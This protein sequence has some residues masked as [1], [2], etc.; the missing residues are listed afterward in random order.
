MAFVNDQQRKGFFSRLNPFVKK[1]NVQPQMQVN[2]T[3]E[4]QQLYAQYTRAEAEYKREP[5][6]DTARE[7]Y[8]F[9]K[10]RMINDRETKNA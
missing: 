3:P 6:N 1:Q 8:Q 9:Y 2:N 4:R 10:T 5:N 7:R